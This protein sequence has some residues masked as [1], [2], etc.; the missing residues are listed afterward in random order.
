MGKKTII[1]R[2]CVLI[3]MLIWMS[4]LNISGSQS[5]NLTYQEH[6]ALKLVTKTASDPCFNHVINIFD[7][8]SCPH[9]KF[10]SALKCSS[11]LNEIY[12]S[13]TESYNK[14][15]NGMDLQSEKNPG[16]GVDDWVSSCHVYNTYKQC[17]QPFDSRCK[18][19]V[20]NIEMSF[21]LGFW[22]PLVESNTISMTCLQR[23]LSM[24]ETMYCHMFHPYN[25][26]RQR[27]EQFFVANLLPIHS[28]I[29]S[30]TYSCIKRSANVEKYCGKDA[31]VLYSK[32]IEY[33]RKGNSILLGANSKY[34]DPPKRNITISKKKSIFEGLK[35]Q[36]SVNCSNVEMLHNSSWN[37]FKYLW[38]LMPTEIDEG[39]YSGYPI[40]RNYFIQNILKKDWYNTVCHIFKYEVSPC[41]RFVQEKCGVSGYRKYM[42]KALSLICTLNFDA[43]SNRVNKVM[44]CT[45]GKDE[46][47]V[48]LAPITIRGHIGFIINGGRYVSYDKSLTHPNIKSIRQQLCWR[49]EK[50]VTEAA[51]VYSKLRY[52]CGDDTVDMLLALRDLLQVGLKNILNSDMLSQND[53]MACPHSWEWKSKYTNDRLFGDAAFV[54]CNIDINQY[55]TDNV[56]K[57]VPLL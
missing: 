55:V 5:S 33:I 51:R 56:W 44:D 54:F 45:D 30:K 48:C 38:S 41:T 17:I 49:M 32:Y 24:K 57:R 40:N 21:G 6:T 29:E 27:R 4:L 37:C 11:K 36:N 10:K 34:S 53:A 15:V 39:W 1:H 18:N 3:W 19:K 26:V 8:F 7:R 2:I 52:R 25:N 16:F 31:S 9:A 14:I 12:L 46:L 23:R 20:L 28:Y 35:N 42:V 43:F 22:C 50:V 13:I 47:A